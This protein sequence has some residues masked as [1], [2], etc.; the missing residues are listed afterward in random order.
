MPLFVEFGDQT[1]SVQ[2]DGHGGFGLVRDDRP[3]GGERP[4]DLLDPS[5]SHELQTGPA[6]QLFEFFS[7]TRHGRPSCL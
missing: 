3:P 7:S 5:V 1:G 6:Q 2:A 4:E